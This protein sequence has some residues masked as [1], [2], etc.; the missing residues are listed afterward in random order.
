LVEENVFESG[1]YEE[2]TSPIKAALSV[3]RAGVAL[4]IGTT[5]VSA[6]LI[7][8]DNGQELL[9]YSAL[10]QQ[11]VFGADVMSRIGAARAGKTK[12]LFD[13]I[14]RQTHGILSG[15]MQKLK[16]PLIETLIVAANTTMLHFFAKV[17]P[18]SMGEVPFKPAFLEERE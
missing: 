14:N 13:I 3:S 8:L 11:R 10:N 16:L 12:E 1:A 9:T 18:S 17:D 15:F 7:D 2:L 4:D 5:T 6:R